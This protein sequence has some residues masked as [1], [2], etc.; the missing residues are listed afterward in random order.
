MN[1]P[2]YSKTENFNI[3][4]IKAIRENTHE[5]DMQGKSVA[6]VS[7]TYKYKGRVLKA[8]ARVVLW[9]YDDGETLLERVD[10]LNIDTVKGCTNETKTK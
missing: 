10:I 1:I 5:K 8:T 4:A 2:D 7:V 3:A 9:G 6:E